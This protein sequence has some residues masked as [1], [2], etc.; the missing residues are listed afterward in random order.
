MFIELLL[1]QP[2]DTPE[3]AVAMDG[4]CSNG[5]RAMP[6]AQDTP[7]VAA[8]NALNLTSFPHC[9]PIRKNISLS[10]ISQINKQRHVR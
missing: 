1:S 9:N 7:S 3:P 4:A 5:L 6:L 2:R 10:P 8:F